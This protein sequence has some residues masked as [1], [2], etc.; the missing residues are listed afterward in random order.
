MESRTMAF[1]TTVEEVS[2]APEPTEAVTNDEAQAEPQEAADN[3]QDEQTDA[4]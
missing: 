1:D 4:R 2:E 3:E